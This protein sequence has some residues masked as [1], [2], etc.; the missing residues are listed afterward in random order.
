[1]EDRQVDLGRQSWLRRSGLPRRRRRVRLGQRAG[2]EGRPG[3]GSKLDDAAADAF[4]DF[5]IDIGATFAD[6]LTK[7]ASRG[8]TKPR[9][10][11]EKKKEQSYFAASFGSV[12]LGTATTADELIPLFLSGA[13]AVGSEQ[14]KVSGVSETT[15]TI[16]R[17][18]STPTTARAL[19]TRTRSEGVGLLKVLRP[20]GQ[21]PHAGPGSSRGHCAI[22]KT[23]EV[24]DRPGRGL[25]SWR[26]SRSEIFQDQ[27]RRKHRRPDPGAEGPGGPGREA[28]G[29]RSMPRWWR[30]RR[31]SA[32][33]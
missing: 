27:P 15:Q 1:M 30:G 7:A 17:I 14:G 11:Q 23:D 5:F 22:S 13:L 12:N 18:C 24:G 2:N 16:F 19:P 29:D 31:N 32:S 9:S 33:I 4:N 8:S 6:D 3:L 28:V 25:Q 20:A 10:G 26:S 21:D